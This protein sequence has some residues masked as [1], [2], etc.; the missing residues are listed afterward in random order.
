MVRLLTSVTALLALSAATC[1]AQDAMLEELYGRGV[2][3]FF[4]GNIGGAFASLTAA[5]QR[6]CRDPRPFYYGGLG[7]S[8]LGRPDEAGAASRKGAE[9]E[10]RGG[11][12]YPV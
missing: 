9:R 1:L 8:R 12:P 2:H 11:E 10:L 3:A 6:G 5:I 4:S 7:L